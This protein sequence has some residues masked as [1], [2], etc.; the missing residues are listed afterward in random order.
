MW[1]G[2][3]STSIGDY[4]ARSM[5]S[6]KTKM[7]QYPKGTVFQVIPSR[8]V[9][10]DRAKLLAELRAFAESQGMTLEDYKPDPGA[11]YLGDD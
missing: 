7:G 8:P 10:P 1:D 6:L 4:R 11:L 3:L 9:A 5:E 2:E